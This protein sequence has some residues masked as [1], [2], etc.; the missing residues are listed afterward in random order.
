[1]VSMGSGPERSVGVAEHGCL[2]AALCGSAA[3][4]LVESVLFI[5]RAERGQKHARALRRAEE[6]AAGPV[7]A[8]E[9][10]KR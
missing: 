2:I 6:R 9:P 10:L 8:L 4:L 5:I 1:M 7:G 3:M